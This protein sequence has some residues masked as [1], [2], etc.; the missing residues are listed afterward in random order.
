MISL[1]CLIGSNQPIAAL[2]NGIYS[3]G[4]GVRNLLNT[5]GVKS[6]IDLTLENIRAASGVSGGTSV[7]RA[8][9]TRWELSAAKHF[10]SSK[11]MPE[12]APVINTCSG[13]MVRRSAF[14]VWGS[15]PGS[16]NSEPGTQNC[17]LANHRLP[18]PKRSVS[19]Q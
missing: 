1:D 16:F 5:A 12:E 13:F 7:P 17:G 3:K 10:A 9:R 6:S 2:S 8:T 11:P 18:Q 14:S 4:T 15:A 19:G